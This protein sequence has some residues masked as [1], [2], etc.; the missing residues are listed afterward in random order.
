[1]TA[2]VQDPAEW[3]PLARP[4]HTHVPAEGSRDHDAPWR[5][6][7]FLAFWDTEA[8]VFG[9]VHVSTSPN[10]EGR[11]AR[12]SVAAAGRQA[13]VIEDLDRGSFRSASIDFDLENS[14]VHVDSPEVAVDLV[15]RPRFVGHG[16]DA[17][18]I[19]D[20]SVDFPLSHFEQGAS[21]VGEVRVGD[22]SIRVDGNGYRDRSWGL[23]DESASIA[24]YAAV[25]VAMPEFNVAL[26]KFM[27]NEGNVRSHGV[28]MYQDRTEQ[29]QDIGYHR[30]ANGLITTAS[31]T[32]TS[33]IVTRLCMQRA[34]GGFWLPMGTG[35]PPPTMSAY[36]DSVDAWIAEDPGVRGAGFTEQGVLRRL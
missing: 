7:A 27:D 18:I 1:M 4:V 33:G 32:G 15:S 25:L 11:R 19:P 28:L 14:R 2:E 31:Y 13:C 36:D 3:G 10:A 24:E 12:C 20:L 21:V 35:G 8:D 30:D 9:T 23:R 5:D 17:G 29:V 16:Y 22:T 6:N 34:R 26:A